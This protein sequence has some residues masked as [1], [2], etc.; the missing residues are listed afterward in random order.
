M[1]DGN[2]AYTMVSTFNK[3]VK[4]YTASSLVN[5]ISSS[6]KWQLLYFIYW[7]WVS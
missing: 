1:S 6:Q 7:A 4:L 2:S 3:P 5:S